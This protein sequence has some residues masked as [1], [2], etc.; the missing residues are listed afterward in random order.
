MDK[1]NRQDLPREKLRKKGAAALTDVEL[2]AA[3]IGS[4][5]KGNDFRQIARNLNDAIKEIGI[6]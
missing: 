1:Q 4:G 3:V 2:L 5:G 6:E